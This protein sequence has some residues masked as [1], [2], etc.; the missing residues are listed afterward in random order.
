ME[1][2]ANH[3]PPLCSVLANDVDDRLELGLDNF[4]SL[5]RF[6]LREL[7]TTAEDNA[8]TGL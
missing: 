4:G 1:R 2:R 7:L 5:A 3:R 8:Q 6:A